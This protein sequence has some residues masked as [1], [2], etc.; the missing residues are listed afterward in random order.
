MFH[1]F[2]DKKQL[3]FNLKFYSHN[4]KPSTWFNMSMWVKNI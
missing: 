4:L 1:Q 2:P 3:A